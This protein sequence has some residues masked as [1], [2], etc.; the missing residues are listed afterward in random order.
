MGF[1]PGVHDL[2]NCKRNQ[3]FR[4]STALVLGWGEFFPSSPQD[5]WQCLDAFSWSKG[6]YLSPSRK[7]FTSWCTESRKRKKQ[8]GEVSMDKIHFSKPH[9]QWSFAFLETLDPKSPLNYVI[10]MDLMMKLVL[11]SHLDNTTNRGPSLQHLR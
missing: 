7:V 4:F 6:G 11:S 1:Y 10:T 3:W 8:G 5:I 2:L 9:Y